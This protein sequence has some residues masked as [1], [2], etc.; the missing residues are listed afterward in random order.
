MGLTEW[1]PGLTPTWTILGPVEDTTGSSHFRKTPS[2][3]VVQK[4][5]GVLTW[6]AHKVG[7]C[8]GRHHLASGARQGWPRQER[9]DGAGEGADT[10]GSHPCRTQEQS[11]QTHRPT[12]ATSGSLQ[13]GALQAGVRVSNVLP[14]MGSQHEVATPP[15]HTPGHSSHGHTQGASQARREVCPKE[16]SPQDDES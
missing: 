12:P 16:R 11:I 7:F 1:M 14:K 13:A 10:P 3:F 6:A 2:L 15:T 9:V 4:H 5:Q 8:T